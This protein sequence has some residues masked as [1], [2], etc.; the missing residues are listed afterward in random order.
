VSLIVFGQSL[1][2]ASAALIA[3]GVTVWFGFLLFVLYYEE[4]RLKH[5]FAE[6]YEAYSAGVPRWIPRFKPWRGDAPGSSTSSSPNTP[7]T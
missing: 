3:Y 4:P 5:Q 2:F 7:R 1:L 6:A